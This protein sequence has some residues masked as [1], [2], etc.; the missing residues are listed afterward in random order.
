LEIITEASLFCIFYST[1]K[2][3]TLWICATK[4]KFLDVS[5]LVSPTAHGH[6]LLSNA[7][8]AGG[9]TMRVR[10][11]RGYLRLG[12]RKK[13][14]DRWEFLWWDSEPSGVRVRRK[15]VI[16]TILQYPN[17][18]N[19]WQASNGL[20]VSINETRNRQREQTITVADLIDH[21]IA[22]ELAS[23]QLDGGKSHATKTIYT[24]FL[25]R[26]VRP[27]W[28]SLNIRD[29]RTIAVENWLRKLTRGNGNPLAPSTK[30]KIRSLMSVLFN[31]AIRHEWL[32]QGRNPILL[33]RQGAKRQRIP[34]W[35][36]PEELSALLSQLDRC[37][38]VMVFL[39]AATGLRRSELLA[40]KWVDIEFESQQIKVQR[41]IYGNVVGNCKTEAS[42][43]PVP[44]DPVLAA[45]LWAWKQRSSYSQPH[46]WVFAS[47]RTKGKNPYWPDIILSR[48]VRPAAARAGIRKHFGWHTFRHSFSTILIGNGENV[49]VVQELMRHSNCRC[50]LEIYSQAR[51]QAKRDAQHRVIQMIIPRNGEATDAEER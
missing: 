28:G 18:E 23:D 27:I 37:F 15:A 33:V 13:G 12:Q 19:A 7:T 26:W 25:T 50:T 45:E 39:D 5:G 46:D 6:K 41:S 35:L 34:E 11:Q 30:A 8:V 47:P 43:K 20:R 40:L 21:Y 10:N 9:G 4:S 3:F 16:G 51:I 2:L 31:H 38:R 32:E 42:K 44:M 14:P 29:V 1:N 49:K 36:E 24:D 48:I 22:T 17:L